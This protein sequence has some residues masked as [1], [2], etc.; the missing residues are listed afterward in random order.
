M[1]EFFDGGVGWIGWWE[2]CYVLGTMEI[3][4]DLMVLQNEKPAGVAG[5][6]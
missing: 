5:H 1:D 4:H 2:L 6:G 3:N